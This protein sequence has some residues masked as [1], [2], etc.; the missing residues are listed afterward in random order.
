MC[1]VP[2]VAERNANA[3]AI[4]AAIRRLVKL[5]GPLPH[6]MRPTSVMPCPAVR[7]S[8]ATAGSN[9]SRP[10]VRIATSASP[11]TVSPPIRAAVPAYVGAS[12]GEQQTAA[13]VAVV[14]LEVDRHRRRRQTA[15]RA[16]G[17][18]DEDERVRVHDLVPPEV[19]ELGRA[20]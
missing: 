12:S 10:A 9:A 20:A 11:N 15:A 2:P 1:A 6:T 3:L 18:F 4:D 16:L 8:S 17:P 14:V 7:I 13:G 19:R 5:P